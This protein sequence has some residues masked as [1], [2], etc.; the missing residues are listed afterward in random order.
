MDIPVTAKTSFDLG[1]TKIYGVFG[2]YL[3][4][5]LSG[6]T[7]LE[8]EYDGEVVSKEEDVRWGS[9]EEADLKKMDFGL[10]VVAGIE[11]NSFQMGLTYSLGLANISPY[12]ENG[13][14]ISN[15]VLGISIGYKIGGK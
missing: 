10:T 5:G 9:D 15:R 12:S 8:L 11:L 7:K 14:K 13:Y 6:K 3:G 2:P 1:N 4:I